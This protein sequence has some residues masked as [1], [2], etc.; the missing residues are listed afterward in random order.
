MKKSGILVALSAVAALGVAGT[1]QANFILRD[2]A[3]PVGSP[4][5]LVPG[6]NNFQS[7]LA[8]NG[9]S[10]FYLGR[11]LSVSGAQVGDEIQV[12]FF[13]AEAA[14]RNQF[15]F[16]GSMLINNQGNQS[17]SAR[18]LGNTAAVNGVQNFQFCT[19]NINRCLTNSNNDTTAVGSLQS[20]GMY[21]TNGG[22][23]AW[24]LWDDSGANMDDNHDDLV[25][26]LTYRSVPEPGTLALLGLGLL[27]IGLARRK[28]VNPA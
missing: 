9:V 3:A 1:A 6:I 10:S 14:Y 5:V 19:V 17:W 28:A 21:L 18:N 20:I 23:T 2:V 13:A 24:L 7:N 26:R 25:V 16:A 4:S 15:I 11:Q 12:D 22:N 27:G 8:S